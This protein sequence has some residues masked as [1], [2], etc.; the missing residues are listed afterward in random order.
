MTDLFGAKRPPARFQTLEILCDA[1]L[2]A[3]ATPV[4]V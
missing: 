1:V 4:C 3:V 2:A